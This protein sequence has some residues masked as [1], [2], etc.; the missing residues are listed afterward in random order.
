MIVSHLRK[1]VFLK[2]RKTAGTSFEIGLSRYAGP[3]DIVTSND[4]EDEAL[5]LDWGGIQPQNWLVPR[6]RWGAR[7]W[8]RWALRRPDRHFYHHM[9]AREIRRFIGR[10]TWNNYCR[11]TIER[12]P[13][14]L[15]VS[16]WAWYARRQAI[17]FH[18]FVALDRL[19]YYSNWRIYTISDRIVVDWVI[20]YDELSSYLPQVSERLGL[21]GVL[22]LPRAKANTRKDRRP[23]QELYGKAEKERVARIFHREI[24]AFGWTFD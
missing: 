2:T 4:P 18:A 7:E 10:A 20:R 11:L 13:W 5:R 24:E 15:V 12:N 22:S 14:D 9:P 17:P 19:P 3:K 21:P 8:L 1:F 23:F 6:S 16:A